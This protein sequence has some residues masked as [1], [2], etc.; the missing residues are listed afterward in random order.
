MWCNNVLHKIVPPDTCIPGLIQ[1]ILSVISHFFV[2]VPKKQKFALA[3]VCLDCRIY[4][5]GGTAYN[6]AECYETVEESYDCCNLSA[7]REHPLRFVL[8]LKDTLCF[9]GL[10]WNAILWLHFVV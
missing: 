1:N 8:S 3:F 10:C 5:A 4:F 2:S 9:V 7:D 6:L